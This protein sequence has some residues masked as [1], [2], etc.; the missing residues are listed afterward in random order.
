MRR[1][2]SGAGQA[3]LIFALA[4]LVAVAY[5]CVKTVPVYV[6]NYELND[7]IRQLA[8]QAT[9][10]HMSADRV[11]RAVLD[12]AQDLELPVHP[13]QVAV[14]AGNKVTITLNYY[15]PIDLKVYSFYLHFT[16]SAENRQI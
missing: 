12:K 13:E 3:K 6:H 8:I 2:D 1:S 5:F 7:Y 4:F 11:Q 10:E 14:T 15:V 9:V 16:P